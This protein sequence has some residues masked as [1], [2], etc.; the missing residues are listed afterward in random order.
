MNAEICDA[1]GR[2]LHSQNCNDRSDEGNEAGI[3]PEILG[4]TTMPDESR[5]PD[6]QTSA[7]AYHRFSAL[8][9]ASKEEEECESALGHEY[10]QGAVFGVFGL[11]VLVSFRSEFLC[12]GLLQSSDHLRFQSLARLQV[13]PWLSSRQDCSVRQTNTVWRGRSWIC[14]T[15]LIENR[16]QRTFLDVSG[17]NRTLISCAKNLTKP[18]KRFPACLHYLYVEYIAGS[19]LTTV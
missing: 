5:P 18:V 3:T 2:R 14:F 19:R 7:R 16:Y 8:W 10:A 12:N 17:P 6:K 1:V 11:I 13:L 9:L 4:G 15:V